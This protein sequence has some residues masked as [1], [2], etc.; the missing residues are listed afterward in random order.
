MSDV[1]PELLD[2]IE[3]AFKTGYDNSDLIKGLLAKV[4]AGNATYEEASLF[5]ETVGDLL[6]DCYGRALSSEVLPDGRMYYNIAKK[7]VEP[8][9]TNNYTLV[10]DYSEQVQTVLNKKAGIG[11]KAQRPEMNQGKIDGIINRLDAAQEFDN[12]AWI[13][14]EPVTNFSMAVVDDAIKANVDFHYKAGLNPTIERIE[15][16]RCCKWCRN[17]AGTYRYPNVPE[18]VYRRHENCRCRVEYDPK[19]GKRQDVH[20]KQWRD[21]ANDD[22]IR[23]RRQFNKNNDFPLLGLGNNGDGNGIGVPKRIGKI[24]MSKI[25]QA[26]EYYGDQLRN[27]DVE[28]AIIIRKNGVVFHS[29]GNETN[30]GVGNIDLKGAYILHNHTEITSL[31][32][33]I[34]FF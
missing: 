18:D 19:N 6:A 31:E 27:L 8:T 20:T 7:V 1:S 25:D 30:V 29:V 3:R 24:D 9:L 26:V 17:L 5:A 12:V 16:Y 33:M 2:Y 10:A 21:T 15:A 4:E 14:K 32:K 23:E 28:N 13:L 34:L 11:L 22:I